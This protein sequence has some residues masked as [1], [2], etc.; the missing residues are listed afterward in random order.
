MNDPNG[1]VYYKGVYHLFYQYNPDGNTWGNMSWGHATSTDLV[2]W[3]EQPLAIPNDSNQDI[4]SGSVVA[5]TTNSSGFGTVDN[6]PLVAIFTSAYKSG[7]YAGLQA[8]SLAYSTDN[9]QTWTKYSG[10]PVLNR[11]SANFRDPKVFRYSGTSDSYWVMTAVEAASHQVVLYKSTDLRDWTYLSTFGP[12]NATGG[13]WETPD[14][15]PLALNGDQND[16][17]W[18]L[19]V[20]INPGAISG[21]SGGQYF[22]GDFD[23]TT[24]TSSDSSYTP[25]A[26]TVLEDFTGS[27]YD[28]WTTTG[29]AFGSGPS[30]GGVDGQQAVTGAAP[31]DGIANSYHGTDA[32]IGTLT[33]PTFTI[34][35]PHLNFLVGGGSHPRV[36]GS[37]N[38]GAGPTGDVLESFD[39][40]AYDGWTTTGTAFG[41]G[42]AQGALP[43]QQTVNGYTGPGLVNSFNGGDA[44]TGTLTSPSF[45]ITHN[46]LDFLLGGG[47]HPW[48]QPNPTSVNLIVDGQVLASATGENSEFLRWARFDVSTYKGQTASVQVVDDNNGTG[49][50]AWGHILADDFLQSDQAASTFQ[51]FQSG[52]LPD[53]VGTGDLA[54]IAPANESLPGQQGSAALDT[55]F[56]NGKGDA[57]QGTLT[58]P[59]FTIGANYIDFLTA[60]GNHPW[61]QPNP[62]SVNLIVGGQV[63]ATATGNNS[64]DMDWTHWDV[65]AYT[66]QEA[67]I[68]IVD[69]NDGSGGWGHIM[70]DDIVFS[71]HAAALYDHSTAVDLLVGGKVVSSTT[72]SNSEAM[73]WA[74]WDTSALVGQQ[75]QIQL[76]DN[77]TGGWGHIEA[78]EFTQS[79]TAALNSMQR[80]N[81]VDYGRDFYAANSFND[82]PNGKRIMIGWMND[83][84]Y[85]QN[86]RTSPWRSAMSLPRELTLQTVDGKPRLV[87]Q[88]VSQLAGVEETDRKYTASSADIT[89]GTTA[90]PA[91]ANAEVAKV[92]VTISQG[93]AKQFGIIVRR[94]A[95]GSEATPVLY[96]TTT[97]QLSLDRRN[98]GDVGFDA[99]FPSV[100]TTPVNLVD[101]KLHL[102]LYL[103]KSSV[104]A[105]AQ[106]GVRTITDQVF[107]KDGSS[108]IALYAAGGTAHLDNLT[109]TPLQDAMWGTPQSITFPPIANITFGAPDI[110]LGATASSGLTVGYSVAGTCALVNGQVH[111]TAA[112]TC[113]VTATQPGD[114]YYNPA[115]AVSQSFTIAPWKLTGFASPVK[116]SNNTI[117]LI[118]AGST[119]PLKF[120]AVE[121][122]AAITDATTL[123]ATFTSTPVSCAG[124]DT[125]S[126]ATVIATTGGTGLRYDPTAMQWIQNWQAPAGSGQCYKVV[127]TTA[128]GSQLRALFQLK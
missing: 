100:E 98:S 58:S 33:S 38:N 51:D 79:D 111:P 55:F 128:D 17:K 124:G 67:Q 60:G 85:G 81:W 123:G 115:P 119:V 93:T 34:T 95:D 105:F 118:K 7:P 80:A 48:G 122:T 87:Q 6:P 75:A 2:H 70:V 28:S 76:V 29:T 104:E 112:G 69:N 30:A 63:V 66:G 10:N 13:V 47:D 21:G 73:D 23:G 127:L 39:G 20:G 77:N 109:V 91:A 18:V 45:T 56:A 36:P 26:G 54:G 24:F 121:E 88:P 53:W 16:I 25:P 90:L 96:D 9:G 32:S 37:D 31:G 52:S 57:G 71:D 44:S 82:A 1:L 50:G 5:D 19:T 62:T 68:Q 27:T 43:G 15:F 3:T 49:A 84:D 92:D 42:P 65:S 72:G 106:G 14:L 107:P 12:A 11:N 108:G 97:A 126:D 110:P 61:G 125:L 114:A 86:I 116:A 74:S 8:Q 22:V 83:W 4:F 120:T 40:S 99:S 94:A 113:T 35:S 46:N 89:A 59:T 101:G 41:D 103:D 117:N 78:A 64:P 102:Q